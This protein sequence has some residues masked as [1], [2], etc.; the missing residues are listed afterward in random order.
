MNTLKIKE[1][2]EKVY[3]EASKEFSGD[4]K[5]LELY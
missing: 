3:S 5:E 2:R 1:I 4:I